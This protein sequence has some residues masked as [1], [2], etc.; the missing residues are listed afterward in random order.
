MLS[1]GEGIPVNKTESDRYIKMVI[2]QANDEYAFNYM[3]K[4]ACDLLNG[5]LYIDN[6][7]FDKSKTDSTIIDKAEAAKFFKIAADNGNAES[8]EQLSNMLRNG[9][10][11]TENIQESIRYLNMAIDKGNFYAKILYARYLFDGFYYEK[12]EEKAE[13]IYDEVIE[14]GDSRHVLEI[15]YCY[16]KGK[17]AKK[18][19]KKAAELY[20]IAYDRGSTKSIEFYLDMVRELEY[21]CDISEYIKYVKI[22][23]DYEDIN[24]MRDY[25]DILR[26][27]GNGSEDLEKSLFYYK[28][29]A[30]LGDIKSMKIY[31]SLHVGTFVGRNDNIAIKYYSKAANLG[32]L[33][34]M[35]K[36]YELIRYSHDNAQEIIDKYERDAEKGDINAMKH[37]AMIY[38]TGYGG[39]TVFANF[40]KYAKMAADKGDTQSMIA[41]AESRDLA[42]QYEKCEEYL[43]KSADK[44]DIEGMKK[45]A[46]YIIKNKAS[47]DNKLITNLYKKAAITGDAEGLFC[48]GCNLK[49]GEGIDE[50]IDKG[51]WCIKMA[52]LKGNTNAMV[53]YG[54]YLLCG[55]DVPIDQ[56]EAA[57]LFKVAAENGSYYGTYYYSLCLKN[58]NGVPKDKKLASKYSNNAKKIQDKKTME[59]EYMQNFREW[60][61]EKSACCI[62]I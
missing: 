3:E 24:S 40:V 43:K 35:N 51:L 61:F 28:L 4:Y 57:R 2:D 54:K 26:F 27:S 44:N 9:D 12:N 1:H 42:M 58:G 5:I 59:L 38:R 39:S 32:D 48:F 62:L 56:T 23:A 17:F 8:M 47:Y 36:Y 37:C 52:A 49:N 53:L 41:Y 19:I 13:R 29:A 16:Q 11:I 14:K 7:P 30:D 34:A 50:N 6:Y 55:V 21:E 22:S 33:E 15:A 18:D 31:A 46:Y 25:A 20:K 10:G 45:Y 60:H